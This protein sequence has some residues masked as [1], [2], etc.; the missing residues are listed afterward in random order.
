MKAGWEMKKLGEL[1]EVVNGGTPKTNILEYWGGKNLW[2]TPAEMGKRSTPYVE[3]TER[4]IT[5]AGLANSSAR[6]LPKNS[7]ILSSRAPIGHLIINS[8]PMATNQGC[9]GLIPKKHIDCKFLYYYLFSIVDI[10][11]SLGTGATFKELSGGKLKEVFI[12]H[13]DISIQRR[14]VAILDEAFAGIAAAKEKAEKNLK[15]AKEVFENHLQFIFTRCSKDWEKTTL[16]KVLD[17]QPQNGWSPP[18]ENHADCG[19]PVLTLSSVTG[20]IFKPDK[21]KFTSADT[22]LSKRYWVKNGDFLM[23]RSNTPELVGHVAIAHGIEKPTIYPDLIMRMIPNQE[24]MVNE[25]L[26]YQMRSPVLREEIRGRAQG[27]NPTMKKISNK[28]AKTLP[29]FAPSVKIQK[30]IVEEVKSLSAETSRL[31]SI[32]QQKLSNLEKLK[33][34]L[35]QQAFSGAL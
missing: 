5:D 16:E 17:I 15:N 6:I 26:Y 27:A 35:L 7:V 30:K 10:L 33:K 25:F 22:N 21:I 20:F 29:I 8:H 3:D 32:Y 11:D 2:I 31:E 23:T 1:C 19:T 4:K 24:Y 14:I 12:P 18:S 9:K 34:S 28:S 13:P